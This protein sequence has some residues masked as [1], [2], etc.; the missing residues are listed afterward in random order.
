MKRIHLTSEE[1]SDLELRHTQCHDRKEG[2][3]IKAVLLHSEGWTVSMISQALRLHAS[4][5]IRHL[6]DYRAGKLNNESGG[7]NSDLS[8]AQTQELILHLEE[9][10]YHH[11]H[12][13]VQYVKSK[14]NLGYSVPGMNKWLH[15]N[16]FSYK[17][18]KGR[19]Y[20]ANRKQQAEFIKIRTYAKL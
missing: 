11:V 12:D 6:N 5:I 9:H 16:R 8:E 17:K 10:T 3:R 19:P 13:I 14:F 20:K 1:K 18:P 7:S 15:R 2:D 4:T